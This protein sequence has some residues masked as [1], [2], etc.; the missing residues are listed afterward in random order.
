MTTMQPTTNEEEREE[1]EKRKEEQEKGR[2]RRGR[3]GA[4]WRKSPHAPLALRSPQEPHSFGSA[5]PAASDE[6]GGDGE[7]DDDERLRR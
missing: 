4:G 5:G 7:G 6:D 2:R 1:A 3:S